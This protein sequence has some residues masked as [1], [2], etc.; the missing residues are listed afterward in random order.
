[1]TTVTIYMYTDVHSLTIT[2]TQ[3]I[4]CR[5]LYKESNAWL[6][7]KATYCDKLWRI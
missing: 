5:I 7:E 4:L 6:H 3:Q 1:M 2:E